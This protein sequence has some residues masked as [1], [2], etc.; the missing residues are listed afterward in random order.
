M[1]SG[2]LIAGVLCFLFGHWVWGLF[3]VWWLSNLFRED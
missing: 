1:K 2:V 3:F